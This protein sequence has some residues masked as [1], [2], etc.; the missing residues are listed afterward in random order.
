MNLFLVKLKCHICVLSCKPRV[1]KD[2]QDFQE[3]QVTKDLKER[4]L[5]WKKSDTVPRHSEIEVVLIHVMR[6]GRHWR[7]SPRPERTPRS[8]RTPR[9][10]NEISKSI[11][12]VMFFIKKPRSVISSMI[13]LC[14]RHLWIWKAQDSQ[15]WNLCGWEEWT[16]KSV[17]SIET[18]WKDRDIFFY[19][20]RDHLVSQAH[21]VLLALLVP[22][23]QA[24]VWV[25][26]QL[27]KQEKTVALV[28]L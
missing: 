28:S 20:W 5:L 18:D 7:G 21:Q 2:L 8:S 1:L 11:T 10:R 12:A 16:L 9:T 23:Q 17:W 3:P 15:I 24:R 22:L 14:F 6:V 27:A 4:R 26:E 13:D 19:C 25:L